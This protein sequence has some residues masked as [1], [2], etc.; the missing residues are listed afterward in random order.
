MVHL[1]ENHH[2]KKKKKTRKERKRKIKE[3]EEEK[4]HFC[5]EPVYGKNCAKQP[6]RCGACFAFSYS[7]YI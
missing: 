2:L 6:E 4:E 7:Y 3:E 5:R 1:I